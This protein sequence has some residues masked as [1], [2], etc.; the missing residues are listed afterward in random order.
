MLVEGISSIRTMKEARLPHTIPTG[1]SNHHQQARR[2]KCLAQGHID[3]DGQSWNLS[4]YLTNS[5]HLSHV[6]AMSTFLNVYFYS[7]K[8]QHCAAWCSPIMLELDLLMS[9]SVA[10]CVFF[11]FLCRQSTFTYRLYGIAG[12]TALMNYK[13][14]KSTNKTIINKNIFCSCT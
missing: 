9:I 6:S 13:L 4:W 2:V 10:R 1:P 12:E 8:L 11:C 14:Y 5:Y 3:Q 7:Y